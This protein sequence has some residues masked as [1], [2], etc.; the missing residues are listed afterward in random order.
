MD[1]LGHTTA[2][3]D[4]K[5]LVSAGGSSILLPSVAYLLVSSSLS[6]YCLCS[7]T[8]QKANF[9][10]DSGMLLFRCV[11][12]LPLLLT[13]RSLNQKF[14]VYNDLPHPAA[15]YIGNNF[16]WR[17][18][19]GSGNN[20][21]IPSMG[22]A[23]TPYSRSVQQYHAIPQNSLPDP[24]LV[25]DTLLKRDGVRHTSI[26]PHIITTHVAL[27]LVCASS[28]RSFQLDVFICC[29]RDPHVSSVHHISLLR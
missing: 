25:F 22:Q 4:R 21:A 24:G 14:T 27:F 5:L 19:D 9:Q 3:D 20:V 16:A 15:T 17:T 2:I 23:G 28:C 29:S 11:R 18:A 13:R 1:A 7:Q 8:C 12:Y 10:R 26:S 6:T